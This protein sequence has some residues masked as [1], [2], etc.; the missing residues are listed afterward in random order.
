M[1]R[2]FDHLST[3]LRVCDTLGW[4]KR[5]QTKRNDIFDWQNQIR[6]LGVW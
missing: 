3:D 1:L 4:A 5:P 2:V 6:Q